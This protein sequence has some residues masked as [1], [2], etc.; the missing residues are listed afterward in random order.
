MFEIRSLESYQENIAIL[1]VDAKKTGMLDN[2]IRTLKKFGEENRC[3]VETQLLSDA[4]AMVKFHC[5]NPRLA[6]HIKAVYSVN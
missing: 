4:I 6:Q 5:G 1:N 3:V 2:L